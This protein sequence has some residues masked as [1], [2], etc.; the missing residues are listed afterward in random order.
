MTF[1]LALNLDPPDEP[2]RTI[3]H[4]GLAVLAGIGLLALGWPIL[5]GALVARLNLEHLYLIGLCGAYAASIYSTVTGVGHI[6]YEVVLILLAIYHLGRFALRHHTEKAADLARHLPGLESPAHIVTEDGVRKIPAAEVKSGQNVRVDAGSLVPVDGIIASG[7]AFIE[8]LAHTGE[9][10][11]AARAAGDR[12]LAGS[13]VLDGTLDITATRDGGDREL[14]RLLAACRDTIPGPAENLARRVLAWFV[15]AVVAIALG[16]A[17][18]WY[19]VGNAPA[20]ALFNALA[21]TIVACPCALGLAIPIA[22]RKALVH[23]RLLGLVAQQP[24]LIE[25]LARIDTIAFDKTGTLSHPRLGLDALE[26]TAAAPPELASWIAAIQ[27]RSTHPVARPFWNLARPAGLEDLAIETLPA[28]GIEARFTHQGTAHRLRIGN[29]LLRPEPPAPQDSGIRRLHILLDGQSVATA[30]L[31]ESPRETALATLETLREMG[32]RRILLTGDTACP[33]DYRE[34]LEIHT[35]LTAA[36]KAGH[37]RAR[38]RDGC[39][40]LFVGDG[41]N[42]SEGLRAAHLGIALGSGA[43]A[44]R[45]TAHAMLAH[46]DLSVLPQAIAIARATRRRLVRL[47][48]FS[49]GY[50]AVGMILAATG[51]LHPVAA[52]LL[53]LVSSATVLTV[54]NR[55]LSPASFRNGLS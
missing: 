46:D 20:D 49:L 47:L 4:S 27:R 41:L 31:A 8:E 7:Q 42:D 39:H 26:T 10:F 44:A 37:L 38:Q 14:D 22:A 2:V 35:A 21:V 54:V 29:E 24:D 12:V 55:P 18:F 33:A 48:T 5:R 15:P 50:N 30:R 3:L 9:P 51:L 6:Y 53:M 25:R 32:L 23:L 40:V 11:P 17:G 13:R 19:F 43:G 1:S 45:A 16:T 52:A 34:V 28:R 36:Q